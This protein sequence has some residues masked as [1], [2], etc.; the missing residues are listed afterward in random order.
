MTADI[1]YLILTD[2]GGDGDGNCFCYFSSAGSG[3]FF[4]GSFDY[5]ALATTSVAGLGGLD[6]TE[7]GTLVDSSLTFT[8]ADGAGLEVCTLFRTCTVAFL[9]GVDNII[10]Y[11]FFTALCRF[12]KSDGNRCFHI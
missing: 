2:T 7:G 12:F 10:L 3:A 1:E 9:A 5:L 4:A 8:V 11:F 6:D